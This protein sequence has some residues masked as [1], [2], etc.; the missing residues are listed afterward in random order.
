MAQDHEM[1]Y[2]PEQF[3]AGILKI[4]ELP[5]I[6][7]LLYSTGKAVIAGIKSAKDIIGIVGRLEVVVGTYA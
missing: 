4:E 2:E 6:T 7:V 5:G 1:I 3:S